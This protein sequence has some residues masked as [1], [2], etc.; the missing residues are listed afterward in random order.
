MSKTK[1]QFKW[2]K[3]RRKSSEADDRQV[4]SLDSQDRELV[5]KAEREGIIVPDQYN[6]SESHSAKRPGRPVFGQLLDL[7]ERGKINALLVWSLNRISRNAVDTGYIIDLMDRGLLLE[8][9]TPGQV[10][11]NTPNDKFQLALYCS[12]AKQENDSKGVDV[13][14]GLKEKAIG[15]GRSGP[16]PLGYINVCDEKGKKSIVPDPERFPIIRKM[17][18]LMLTGNYSVSKIMEVI[19][20]DIGLRT[21]IRKN[22]SGNKKITKGLAYYILNRPFYY[23]EFEFPLGSGNHY[24]GNHVPMITREEFDRVQ[25]L[26]G[27]KGRPRP[28]TRTFTSRGPIHCGEC[29]GSVTAEVKHHCVCT[30]CKHKFSYI[31][32]TEC[33]KCHTDME[34]MKNPVTRSYVLYHCTKRVNKDC[35]QGSINE[36][37]LER[38]L[39]TELTRLEVSPRFKDWALGV[40]KRQNSNESADREAI[41]KS[42][43]KEYDNVVEK[44]DNLIDMRADK[45]I[46]KDEYRRKKA[47]LLAEKARINGLL[48]ETDK[49]IENWLEVAE[50]G[51]DFAETARERFNADTSEDLQVRKEVF[52]TLGS[53]YTLKDKKISIQADD[54]LFAIKKVKE[55]TASVI[56]PFE[57]TQKGSIAM[58][59]EPSYVLSTNELRD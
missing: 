11:T 10:F 36:D 4:A 53:N 23:G 37:E 21:P 13:V 1:T 47:I 52:A 51:F 50:R 27:R 41:I 56:S 12:I 7:V 33:P 16:A 48:G 8:I 15:G 31:Q 24:K 59:M 17:W 49:R 55:A 22:G 30:N 2:G 54:L 29:G 35:S 20:D 3:Y 5:E 25:V 45:E 26:L 38:Q 19:N 46:D 44:I 39:V 18:T 58:Q 14:R 42:Q 28:K 43:R 57:P 40:M 6:L 34:N 9:R 32:K